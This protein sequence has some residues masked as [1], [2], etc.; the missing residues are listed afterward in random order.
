LG[1]E[2]TTKV[3]RTPHLARGS[4]R[5]GRC[6]SLPAVLLAAA[7][8]LAACQGSGPSSSSTPSTSSR[9]STAGYGAFTDP[10]PVTIEGYSGDAMEPF[11]SR[12]G[13][14]L[15]FNTSN[16]APDTAL[17]YATRVNDQTFT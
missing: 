15:L 8:C 12:D 4:G 5:R 9:A 10:Q 13:R 14:Y 7:L 1:D 16:N 17:Q 2:M 6:V 11:I 3:N